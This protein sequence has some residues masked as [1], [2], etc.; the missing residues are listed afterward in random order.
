[1]SGVAEEL[2]ARWQLTPDGDP[3][4]GHSS[5]LLPVRT[6]AGA[7]AMLKVGGSPVEHLALRRWDGDGAARLL[8][9][10]PP[11]RALLIERLGRDLRSVPDDEACEVIAG[12]YRRLHV[13]VHPKLPSLSAEVERRAAE[14]AALPRNAAV[15]HRLVEQA[16][17]LSRELAGGRDTAVLHGNLHAGTVLAGERVPWLAV[18]PDPCNGDPPAELAPMLLHA[19]GERSDD[20]RAAIRRRFFALVDA[21][22]FDEERAR[23]W[24]VVRSV[25]AALADPARMTAGVAVAKAV[26]G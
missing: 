3:V 20:L 13:P 24:V 1:M 8:R 14:L 25:H 18:G 17:T 22:G 9:A 7:A 10:D 23:A 19:A 16:V 4:T 6:G 21:A 2:L 26:Q 15:P 5:Q 12:L 11:R